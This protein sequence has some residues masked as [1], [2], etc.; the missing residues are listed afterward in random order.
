MK[1]LLA[2]LSIAVLLCSCAAE[3]RLARFL[4]RHPELQ[5]VDTIYV[6]DTVIRPME[7]NTTTIT[8][9]DIITMDSIA[10]AASDTTV[11]ATDSSLP[12]VI[13]AT[14]RSEAALSAN[15]DGTFSLASTAK[16]DTIVRVDTITQMH[17]V[18]AYKD[19]PVEVLKMRWWE[20]GLAFTGALALILA[21]IA[22]GAWALVKFAKPL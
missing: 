7:T 5:Y 15:G 16:P 20:K 19:R 14:G 6:H 1:K 10:K 8:L 21:I 12:M 22:I 9:S 11:K 2:I 4:E 3:K 18:T 17:Y 13:V